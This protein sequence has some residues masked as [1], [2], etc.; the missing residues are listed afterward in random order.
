[1]SNLP[2]VLPCSWS[3]CIITLSGHLA[4]IS[5]PWVNP[6][7]R[8]GPRDQVTALANRGTEEEHMGRVFSAYGIPLTKVSLFMWL[9]QT[10]FPTDN[11]WPAMER[12]L[13]RAQGKWGQLTKILGREGSKNRTAGRFYV[14]VVQ[15]VLL[16]G[17]KTWVLTTRLEKSLAGFHHRAGTADGG[18]GPQTLAGQDVGVPT[19]WIGSGNIGTGGYLSIYRP[20]PEHSRAYHGIVFGGRS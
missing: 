18:N 19:Y 5:S 2:I 9:V 17:S 1:M 4:V 12:N 8:R 13:C 10:L 15:A 14:A 16:F 11:D 7:H 6:R 20:T 3:V